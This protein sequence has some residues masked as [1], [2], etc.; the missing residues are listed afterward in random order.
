MPKPRTKDNIDKPV[1][2]EVL[3]NSLPE[4]CISETPA[5]RCIVKTTPETGWQKKN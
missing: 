1:A 3:T 2:L 5:L 4:R